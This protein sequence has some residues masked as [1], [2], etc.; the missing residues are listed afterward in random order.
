MRI[1]NPT[2][3][4]GGQKPLFNRSNVL[5][6]VLV[7]LGSAVVS[8]AALAQ[9]PQN[10]SAN[11]QRQ[12]PNYPPGLCY[13]GQRDMSGSWVN[14]G[15]GKL[16]RLEDLCQVAIQHHET[17]MDIHPV[18]TA[19]WQAFT[20][21]ASP[22]ALGFANDA[23]VEEVITYGQTICPSLYELGTMD[24]LRVVQAQGGLP[25]S[26]DAAVNVAAIH[27]YCPDK[28]RSIGR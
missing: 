7:L 14:D 4:L 1:S 27:T 24:E 20:V 12:S 8:P 17:M 21:A 13:L 26:F 28:A 15:T 6:S 2:R 11:A 25:A 5:C 3:S 18:E 23:G 19:F 16:V 9:S 10:A 22:D